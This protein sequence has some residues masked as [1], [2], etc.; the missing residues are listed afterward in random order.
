MAI[1]YSAKWM[2]ISFS[3]KWMFNMIHEMNEK[4]NGKRVICRINVKYDE[5]SR[6]KTSKIL[7]AICKICTTVL[8]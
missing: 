6:Q 2:A 8:F 5:K 4:R 7:R 3:V 1:R